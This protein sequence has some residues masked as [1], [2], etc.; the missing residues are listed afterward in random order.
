MHQN[1]PDVCQE[2]TD[3]EAG[4]PCE[5]VWKKVKEGRVEAINAAKLWPQTQCGKQEE[6]MLS[7]KTLMMQKSAELEECQ[8]IRKQL[9]MLK[10]FK[11]SFL[12]GYTD[13]NDSEK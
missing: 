4:D 12:S 3:A 6:A 1:N 5:V 13:G 10:E 8:V 9:T 2:P 7:A 11:A